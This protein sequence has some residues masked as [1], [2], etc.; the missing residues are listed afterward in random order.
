MAVQGGCVYGEC[1]NLPQLKDRVKQ[2]WNQRVIFDKVYEELKP[3]LRQALEFDPT[4][5]LSATELLQVL[6]KD[7]SPFIRESSDGG[8]FSPLNEL[9]QLV[10][11]LPEAIILHLMPIN[12]RQSLLTRLDQLSSLPNLTKLE[13]SNIAALVSRLR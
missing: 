7:L 5:R 8:S 12:E 6:K 11:Y 1:G 3:V 10:A 4:K 13:Q 2:E 9:K